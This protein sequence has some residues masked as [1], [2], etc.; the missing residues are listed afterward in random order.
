M[1]LWENQDNQSAYYIKTSQPPTG[2]KRLRV[3]WST[4]DYARGVTEV[5]NPQVGSRICATATSTYDDNRIWVSSI[6]WVVKD[7]GIDTA[8][9]GS[10]YARAQ[11][12]IP[13]LVMRPADYIFVTRIEGWRV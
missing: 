7:E 12:S 4:N 9:N 11:C 10:Y 6:V 5:M 1:L 13:P 2:F 8:M 3:Y